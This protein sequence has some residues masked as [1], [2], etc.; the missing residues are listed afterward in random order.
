MQ[1]ITSLMAHQS[2]AVAKVERA[3]V[4]ALFMEMGTGKSLTALQL[5]ALRSARISRVV[6]FTPVSL[7]DSTRLEI[8]KHA[9]FEAGEIGVHV[10]DDKT[11]RRNLPDAL[12]HICGI[13][14]MSSSPRVLGAVAQL[15][16]ARALVIVD[17]SSYIKGHDS[18]RTRW[19]T[20]VAARVR[21]R[22]ILTGT[23]ISQGVVDLFAQLRFLSPD[24]LGYK[25]FYSFARNHLEYSEKY[26]GVITRSHN[27]AFIAAKMAP[28]VYQVTKAECLDLPP[29]IM[30][31]RNYSMGSE[32]RTYY[33]RAKDELLLQI[34]ERD[35]TST[36]IFRLFSALQQI[37]CG[38]W[39]RIEHRGRGK[40]YERIEEKFVFPHDRLDL[41]CAAIREI[42]P[43]EKVIIWAK[44]R[45]CIADIAVRLES[46]F[47]ETPA[48]FYGDLSES[49]RADQVTRF[50]ADARFFVATPSSGGHGLTLNE[51]HHVIFYTDGFKYAERLQAE[52]RCHRIGQQS[53]VSY[54]SLVCNNSIDERIQK[55]LATKGNAVDEF[56]REVER[57]K[58][59]KTLAQAIKSL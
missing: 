56:R 34:N 21:Y 46:E 3:R 8:E 12:I 26:P 2:A 10:F 44:Y 27:T 15:C 53:S 17:E 28:Y 9:R 4:G 57:I 49:E 41:L 35:V 6:W 39:N 14:S 54:I 13:E 36:D 25:S 43:S 51:A 45:H 33:E 18:S 55:A 11:A 52:D 37:A 30:M 47:G 32:Q 1:I 31:Q 48:L 23:P 59:K 19:I 58:D 22:L 42:A 16:D 50:R 20:R 40:N 24:I 29:K 5:I 38:F 7:K